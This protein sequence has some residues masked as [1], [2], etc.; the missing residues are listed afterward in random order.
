MDLVNRAPR[1]QAYE[2]LQHH[3]CFWGIAL[4]E[5]A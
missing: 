1:D 2:N 3:R 5:Q 4:K